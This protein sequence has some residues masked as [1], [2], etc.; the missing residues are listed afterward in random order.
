MYQRPYTVEEIKKIYPEKAEILLKDSPHLWRAE[1]G[2]EL[3]HKEPTLDEQKRIW[4][5]WNN[6]TEEMKSISDTKSREL[7]GVDNATHY[8]DIMQHWTA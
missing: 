7:F 3:I 2:I 5:N 8:R 1:T 4:E 6:M